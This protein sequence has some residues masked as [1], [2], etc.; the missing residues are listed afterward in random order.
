MQI[1]RAYRYRFY[2]TSEQETILART[3]GCARFAYNYMLRLRTDA[4]YER[5]ERVG[6]LQTS[7]ALTRLKRN[8]EY[9]WLSEVSSVP[10]QQALR[11]LQTAFSNFFSRRAAYPAFHSKHGAQSATYVATGFSF[12]PEKR[13]LTMARM[14]SPLDIRWSRT[15]PRAARVTTVTVSRDPAGRYFASLLCD[16]EVESLSPAEGQIGIDMGLNHFLVTSAGEKVIAP[17]FFRKQG[18][19][20]AKLQRMAARKLEQAKIKA[21][22]PKGKAIPKGT[23]IERS[24]NFRKIRKKISRLHGK[25][26]DSR[27]D[28]QHKL[29]TRLIRENQTISVETLAVKNMS[30]T[31]K[32]TTGSPGRKVR[33]KSCLNRSILDASWSE[34]I[35][36]LEYKARW[37]G[38]TLIGIDRWYPSSKRC[39]GCGFVMSKLPLSART[40]SC[41]GCGSKH[42]RD[43]NAARNILAAGL[44]VS[45]LGEN[46]SPGVAH[47]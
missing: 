11:H 31:A 8:P 23:R 34:F 26:A 17:Q 15:I 38:R 9:A 16:D 6:Y 10:V 22:I 40:W 47:A 5:Q 46:V 32:G 36:M 12:N 44:A 3:F 13:E 37:Y 1:K 29:S 27:R 43:V 21:G 25:I 18:K 33:Q 20:L 30:R 4:W 14:D 39:S 19:K 45:A 24:Q 7:S 35:R 42:D 2:P 28:F 41:P